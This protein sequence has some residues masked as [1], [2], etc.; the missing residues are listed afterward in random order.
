M[1][2]TS[3]FLLAQLFCWA[4]VLCGQQGLVG[5]YF[6]G[7]QFQE[8]KMTRTDAQI[9][10]YW[11]RTA[12]AAG[13]NPQAFSV[14][15]T[16]RIKAPKTGTYVFRAKVDDGIRVRVGETLVINAWQLNDHVALSGK[17][18]LKAGQLYNL[19][20]E[21]F[22]GLLEGEIQLFWQLPG[23]EPAFGGLFG[24]NDKLIT[25]QYFFQPPTATAPPPDRKPQSTTP[26]KKPAKPKPKPQPAAPAPTA[27][28]KDSLERYVPKNVMFEQSKSILLVDSYPELD[29]FAAFL[30]RN[31]SVQVSIEGHTDNH[32]DSAKNQTLSEE[33]AQRVANYLVKKG[34]VP[35]RLRTKGYG[36]TRPLNREKAAQGYAQN[37]R[38]E[39]ILTE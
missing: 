6:N 27:L 25:S 21:Y 23:E 35:G 14:R 29:R 2:K 15:W 1:K 37:R 36:D 19:Q 30:L 10:F 34:V 39:F 26:V 38:V 33:R 4:H 3:L 9:N 7:T 18:H 24:N 16:G 31:V 28:A 22:N 20:V 32:G 11:D 8:K 5:E 13:I 12:P 17:I